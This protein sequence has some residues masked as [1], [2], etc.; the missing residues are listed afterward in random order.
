[1]PS[2]QIVLATFWPRP[3]S[4]RLSFAAL[5]Y[6]PIMTLSTTIICLLIARCRPSQWL[7]GGVMGWRIVI[8]ESLEAFFSSDVCAGKDKINSSYHRLI[9]ESCIYAIFIP[10]PPTPSPPPLLSK[11]RVNLFISFSSLG[12]QN[13]NNLSV[14]WRVFFPPL[15]LRGR[16]ERNGT[17][18]GRRGR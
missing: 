15:V 16:V 3:G 9:A 14:F 1:M 6:C 11:C 17:E 10:Q 18:A 8:M 12:E 13:L 5:V 4:S 2:L 7:N